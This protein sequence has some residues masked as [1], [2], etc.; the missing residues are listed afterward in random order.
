MTPTEWKG[1]LQNYKP[2]V[3]LES[4]RER[5]KEGENKINEERKERM[6]ERT[7]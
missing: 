1:K 2:M 7:Y 4:K 5:E 3:V 6:E